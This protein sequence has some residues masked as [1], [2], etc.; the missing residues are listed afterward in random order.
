[1]PSRLPYPRSLP[2][3]ARLTAWYVGLLATILTAVGVFLPLRLSRDLVAGIDRTLDAGAAQI[4][5]A[6]QETEVGF[7]DA[8]DASLAGL[9]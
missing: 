1:M 6:N 7:Q 3:R 9:T 2:I 5:P 8:S 4:S